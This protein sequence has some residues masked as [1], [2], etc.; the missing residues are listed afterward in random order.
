MLA[1]LA[2]RISI[3]NLDLSLLSLNEPLSHSEFGLVFSDIFSIPNLLDSINLYLG[4]SGLILYEASHFL[5]RCCVHSERMPT[6][7][8]W[9]RDPLGSHVKLF[10]CL[11]NSVDGPSTELVPQPFLDPVTREWEMIRTQPDSPLLDQLCSIISQFNPS[12]IHQS[13]GSI[14]LLDTNCIHRGNYRLSST[15]H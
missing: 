2:S 9:H 13:I 11:H 3:N 6:S 10:L 7:G 4:N 12:Q 15:E 14:L 1:E 8:H 5:Q